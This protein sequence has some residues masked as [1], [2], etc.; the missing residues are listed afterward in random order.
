MA[1][2]FQLI[3]SGYML[4]ANFQKILMMQAVVEIASQ[5]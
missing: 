3:I 2:F 5:R 4:P 1:I